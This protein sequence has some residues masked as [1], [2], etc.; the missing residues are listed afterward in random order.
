MAKPPFTQR[1]ARRLRLFLLT[2]LGLCCLMISSAHPALAQARTAPP[3]QLQERDYNIPAQSLNSAVAVFAT[4]SDVDVLYDLKL[5]VNRQSNPVVGHFTPQRAILVLLEGTGLIC[6]FTSPN[7]A[8]IFLADRPDADAALLLPRRGPSIDLNTMRVTAA[9]LIGHAEN[10]RFD[11]YGQTAQT[12]IYRSLRSDPRLRAR[13]FQIEIKVRVNPKGQIIDTDLVMGTGT[14][15]L[16]RTI[17]AVLDHTDVRQPPPPDMPM[18]L[19]Y[20]I[21][22]GQPQ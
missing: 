6:K 12:E 14:P 18:P 20:R 11:A 19:R 9:P 1:R 13:P 10:S 17:V 2:S 4:T 22:L 15:E 8:V 16:D 21:V 5:G 7:A 3:P